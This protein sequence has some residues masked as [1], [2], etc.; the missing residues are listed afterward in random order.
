[1]KHFYM[2]LL[3]L[4]ICTLQSRAQYTVAT[5]DGSNQYTAITKDNADNIY[6][7]RLNNSTLKGEVVKFTNGNPT[8]TV[9]YGNLSFAGGL[10][11]AYSWGIAVNAAGNVFVTNP[12]DPSNWEIVKLTAPSYTA[13]VIQSGRFF[14]TVAVDRSNNLLAMEYN[15]T[16]NTY[17]L[18]RYPVGAEQLSGS[19]VWSGVPLPTGLSY[20]YPPGIVVDSH[21]NIYVLDFPVNNGGQLFKLTAPGFGATLMGSNKGYTALAIDAADNIYTIEAVDASTSRIMKYADPAG[22]GTQ[23]YTGLTRTLGG[24]PLGLVVTSGGTV[25][26]GEFS[27][28]PTGRL[29]TLSPPSITVSS[30]NRTGTNPSNTATVQYTVT[31]SGAASN[32]TTSSFALT[33]TGITGASIASVAGSG[34]TYTVTVNTGTG[35]GTL[36]LDVNGTGIT[37]VVS[38]VPYT[39]GQV[40]TI[41]KTAS[42]ISSVTVPADGYYKAGNTL[43]FTVNFDENVT[44][45]GT[46]YLDVTI[47]STAV[48]ANYTGGSGTSALTFVYT[49][50]AGDNDM[51]GIALNSLLLNS[52]TI[53]DAA[54]N[55]ATLTLNS[56][57]STTGV[58]VNTVIPT[59][60][61]STN[62][63]LRVNAPFTVTIVFSEVV[64]GLTT[65]DFSVTNATLSNLQTTDNITYTVLVTPVADGSVTIQLPANS[66]VNVGTNGNSATGTITRTYDVTAPVITSVTVP[67]NGYYKAGD[68]LNFAVNASEIINV[69]TTGGTPYLTITIGVTPVQATYVSGSGTSALTFS[70]TVQPGDMD[71]NGITLNSLQLNGGTIRDVATNNA[72][73]TLNNVGNTTSVFV[74]TAIPTVTLSTAAPALVNAPFTISV[75]FSEV[76]TGLTSSDFTVTNATTGVPTTTNNITYTVLVTPVADGSVSI[77][78]PA[79]AAVNIGSNANTASNTLSLTYDA[80]APMVTSVDVPANGYYRIGDNLTFTVHTNEIVNVNGAPVL[81][82]VIGS[83]TVP[84]PFVSGSGSNA[85]IF[86]YTVVP[87]DMDLNGITVGSIILNG[88]TIRD[89]AGNNMVL[90]LSSVGTTTGVL[91]N[92]ANPTV[93]LSTTAPALVNASY[94][95]TITFSES[96]TGFTTG[97]ITATNATVSNLQTTDNITYTVLVTPAADGTIQL[98]VPANMTLNVG[99]NGNDISNTLTNTYDGTAPVITSVVVPTNGYYKAGNTLSFT[100]NFSETVL[101]FAPIGTPYLDVILNSGTVRA[102]L[103]SGTGNTM[104]FKYTV[105]NGDMDMDGIT[106]GATLQLNN[107]IIRDAATN[108]AIVTL[109]NIDPTNNVFV[110]TG[111]PSVTLSTTAPAQVNAPF[112]VTVVFNEAATGLTAA[113]F[114]TTNATLSNLQTTD[115]ISYTVLVTPTTDGSVSIQLPADAAV[116]IGNN[117]N[118]ASNTLTRTLDATAPII[119]AVSVPTNGYYKAGTNLDFT[120]NFNETIVLNTT[121]G[122]PY[123]NVVFTTGTVQATFVSATATALTFRYTVQ[124]GDMDMN[125]IALGA[126][127][128]LNNATITDAAT[129]NANVTLQNVAPTNNVF[130]NTAHPSVTLSTT[131]ASRVNAP[132]TVTVAFNEAVTGLAVADFTTTNATTSNLQTTDNITYTVVVTPTADGLVS[133]QLPVNAAQNIG[134]NDNTASNTITLTRDATAPVITAA[135]NFPILQNSTAGTVIGQVLGTDAA[136]TLQNWTITSDPSG[137]AFAINASTGIITVNN[138][139]ILNNNVGNTVTI[140]VTVSDGLNASTATAVSIKV[141]AINKAPILDAINN[142]VIC[143]T[144]NAHTIQLTGASAVEPTQTYTLS[145]ASNQAYFSALTVSQ[146][147][148]I[149]YQLNNNVPAGTATITVTI[150]DNGGIL[151]GGV[152][153]YQRTFTITVNSLPV[154][155]ITSDKGNSV[156][157]GDIVHL[158]ATGGATYNWDANSSILSGQQA[159]I[160]EVRPQ[161]NITYHVTATNA[162]GCSSDASFNLSIIEDFKVDA[163][164]ILTPNG[165]GKNDKWVIRNIDSYPDNE[166][167]IFDR[168]GRIVYSQ[169]NYNNTWDGTANGHPLAEGTYY[170][171]LSISSG[172]KTAKGF[173]TIL[174]KAN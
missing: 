20:T 103:A 22:A 24:D 79:N 117:G 34:T 111:H 114:S 4:L 165:D 70:Y 15:S 151:N 63:A 7:V 101:M 42:T 31:F 94:T 92:T 8:P 33:T 121:S 21:D 11:S 50:Q 106:L 48:H 1:M 120:V 6:A 133:I 174:R 122:S 97:D 164:N 156:S 157:K 119:T 32:V 170:Y 17:Q 72:N 131:A 43:T 90:T 58:L 113:G 74:N 46:P 159:A 138:G 16:A 108:N 9:I 169:R 128:Q 44:V 52:G 35:N 68:V 116:N 36:R 135:Q 71:M 53:K 153:T 37:P 5:F 19:V 13:T 166:L 67:A 98:Q 129:N 57:G 56:V 14:S 96:V 152:D 115:N 134:G 172:A 161:A 141:N 125:G 28:A 40:Y 155:T 69:N 10:A 86:Q 149:N 105:Q 154:V 45:T 137:G 87:G 136:G 171:Y 29:I 60:T 47:G 55:N 167:K 75:T 145:I 160:A 89:A 91:V 144:T 95:A 147:G 12:H 173:I 26:A 109:Q 61:L 163:T 54:G 49:V 78:V 85:L 73:V 38:N 102:T 112:T 65:G 18:V 66:A 93:T 126:N 41:D 59:V 77:Q 146:A 80:T 2:L 104:T 150:K 132:F 143:A 142:V 64:T 139:T 62:A 25:Y 168:S 100:V 127:L 118:T 83:T 99:G 130:V 124:N 107:A 51:N 23:L 110:N 3:G 30:A 162:N 39:S 84:V 123:L 148:L 158:T 76:V 27:F 140:L 81:R 88:G 82:I